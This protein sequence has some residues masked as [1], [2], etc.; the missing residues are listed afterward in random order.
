[1]KLPPIVLSSDF[2]LMRQSLN[3]GVAQNYTGSI[4]KA[5]YFGHP[6]DA[7]EVLHGSV[8]AVVDI[9]F[10]SHFRQ[11]AYHISSKG[12]TESVITIVYSTCHGK[13]SKAW[14]SRNG[15]KACRRK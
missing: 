6:S 7:Q 11:A 4:R 13:A 8:F 9:Y 14:H 3:G 10:V 15:S 12:L 1:M 5:S 2:S